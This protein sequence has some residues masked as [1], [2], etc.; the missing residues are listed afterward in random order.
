MKFQTIPPPPTLAEYVRFFWILEGDQP[1]VHRCLADGGVEMVFHYQ[2]IFDEVESNSIERSSFSEL[3]GPSS[4]YHIYQC[5]T[6]F[7]IF[8]VYF[9]PF[10]VPVLF[11]AAASELSNET[12]D[13][14]TILGKYGAQLEEQMIMAPSN[15]HRFNIIKTFLENRLRNSCL[16]DQRIQYAIKSV[17]QSN[18]LV[19]LDN[20]VGQCFLSRRQFQRKFKYYAGF[21]PKT[22]A[23][24]VRFQ[25]A[26]D[27]YHRRDKPLVRIALDHGYY[28]QAHFSNDFKKF[29][30]YNPKDYFTGNVIGN[31]WREGD[32]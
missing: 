3:H 21:S 14:P 13:L 29:S 10:A 12:P 20:I 15:L 16:K 30:G 17:I 1:Y 25:A 7:G 31:E 23:K 24:I 6:S 27:E 11:K 28:D 19:L 22:Y 5:G 32:N 4:N 26:A 8:G 18:G 2:G 9:Y